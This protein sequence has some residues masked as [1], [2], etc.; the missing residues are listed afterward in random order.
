MTNPTLRC[1][2]PHRQRD[3]RKPPLIA[4]DS[5]LVELQRLTIREVRVLV[6]LSESRIRELIAQKRFPAPDY[7][8]GPRCVR[9]SAGLVR[10][11]LVATSTAEA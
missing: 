2:A 5:D 7:R 4:T 1:I 10:Q 3:T 11:W 8:A 6:G 9:W